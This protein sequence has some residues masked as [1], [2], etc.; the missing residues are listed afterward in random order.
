MPTTA[1]QDRKF[2]R[3]IIP[4]CL[5]EDAIAWISTNLSPEDVFSKEQLRLW[6]ADN[7]MID[8]RY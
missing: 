1:I 6:A 7:N 5:L 8:D 4:D 3:D 2:I